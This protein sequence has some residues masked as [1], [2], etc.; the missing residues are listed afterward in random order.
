MESTI[1]KINFLKNENCIFSFFKTWNMDLNFIFRFFFE[2]QTLISIWVWMHGIWL[3]RQRAFVWFLDVC[4]VSRLILFN[5][6]YLEWWLFNKPNG[7]LENGLLKCSRS[8]N[9]IIDG[10]VQCC[11]EKTSLIQIRFFGWGKGF[12]SYCTKK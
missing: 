10:P 5:C 2:I 3:W 8:F 9:L 1:Q 12:M 6:F 7:L 4:F 11:P